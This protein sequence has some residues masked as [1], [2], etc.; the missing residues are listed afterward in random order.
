MPYYLISF[1]MCTSVVCCRN[2]YVYEYIRIHIIIIKKPNKRKCHLEYSRHVCLFIY[3]LVEAKL[4]FH[5]STEVALIMQPLKWIF[6]CA[7]LKMLLLMLC[8]PTLLKTL[9]QNIDLKPHHPLHS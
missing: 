9:I 4:G 2:Y 7:T 3:L 6:N 5:Q 1:G 8:S